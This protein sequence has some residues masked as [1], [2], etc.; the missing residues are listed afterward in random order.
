[1]V[2]HEEGG[3]RQKIIRFHPDKSYLKRHN[4]DASHNYL[5]QLDKDF[6][7]YLEY[8]EV[9]GKRKAVI[10]VENARPV[11]KYSIGGT[12]K[13]PS[14]STSKVAE[15]GFGTMSGWEECYEI[16]D[17]VYAEV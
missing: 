2:F 15:D 8:L 7:G 13:A 9:T 3:Y 4:F 14:M 17:D 10:R 11:R 1:I 16:C 6:S 12:I 5:H